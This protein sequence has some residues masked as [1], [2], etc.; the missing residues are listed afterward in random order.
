MWRRFAFLPVLAVAFFAAELR[1]DFILDPQPDAEEFH[2]ESAVHPTGDVLLTWTRQQEPGR[3][4]TAMA[5]ILDPNSGQLGELHEWGPGDTQQ[6]VPLGAGYLA[7]RLHVD[8]NPEW[9]VDRLDASG[10]LIGTA[11]RPGFVA[12]MVAH[13][14]PDGGAVVVASGVTGT[15]GLL[16]AWRFGPDGALLSGPTTLADNSLKT[17][18]GADA[19][20]NLVV[21][22]T[23]AGLRVFARRFSPDL[24]PLG[25]V[26]P[27]ALGGA[28]GIRVAVAP[29]GR[30]V[31]VYAQ[32]YELWARPF[33][34]NGSSAGGRLRFSPRPDTVV[35]ENFD[36]AIG[37]DG[38]I[39]VVWKAYENFNIPIIRA[40]FLSL[41]GRPLGKILRLAR[42]SGGRGELLPPRTESLSEGDFLIL[43]TH[44]NAAGDTLTLRGRRF[45]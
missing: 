43:W 26:I 40:R 9:V 41:A 3:V 45:R 32:F 15:G 11:L 19:D 17:A 13:R 22:W 37:P 39:L 10:R 27:V 12:S 6:V 30:F 33:R 16:Q 14:T 31:V 18:V 24:Q 4:W 7:L 44:V 5:A 8:L 2:G 38:R 20:G 34:A 1:A 42:I 36:V 35:M 25:P 23:D 21:V 29:D 28:R